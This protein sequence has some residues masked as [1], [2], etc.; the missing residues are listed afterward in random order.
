MFKKLTHKIEQ[1]LAAAPHVVVGISGFGGAGK[2]TLANQLRDYFGIADAQVVRL[3]NIFAEDHANKPI[4]ED[5]D[6]PIIIGL[7]E[8]IKKSEKLTY[9]GRG[10]YGEQINFNEQLPKVVIVEGVRLFKPDVMPYFDVTVW[11]DC[12]PEI[13]AQRGRERDRTNGASEAHLRRWQHE[14]LPKDLDY[15]DR[16]EP[17]KFVDFTYRTQ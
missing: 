17:K 3:D 12:P 14:W 1:R 2:T 5:Y 15:F 16:Y 6:W 4:F 11:V 10:F 7:L 13:A 8:N 9:K